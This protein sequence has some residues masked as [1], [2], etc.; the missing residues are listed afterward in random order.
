MAVEAGRGLESRAL[1]RDAAA[2]VNGRPEHDATP[3]DLSKLLSPASWQP[4]S[5]RPSPE[6]KKAIGFVEATVGDA[7]RLLA[8]AKRRGVDCTAVE[9]ELRELLGAHA[10]GPLKIDSAWELYTGLK[11]TLLLIADRRYISTLLDYEAVR[12]TQPGRWHRWADHFAEAELTRLRRALGGNSGQNGDADE[13]L[14][15]ASDRLG[16]LYLKRAEAGRERRAK[17]AQKCRYMY[18]LAPVLLALLVVLAAAIAYVSGGEIWR[19][20]VLAASAGAVGS[21]LS[22]T[23]KLRDE[24]VELDDLRAFMPTMSI[25]PLVGAATGLVLLLV[26]E[27]GAIQ[28]SGSQE[29]GWAIRG[30]LAFAAGFSEP[31]FLGVVQRVAHVPD[32]QAA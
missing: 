27:S 6:L 22:G 15:R 17:A 4:R 26:I 18:I 31:F 25:Q 2:Q 1:P 20:V 19:M 11:K 21:V 10:V 3:G 14:H 23:L 24:L 5:R 16:F 8:Q 7:R 9:Q 28:F 30:L 32:K 29:E 12:D 13:A